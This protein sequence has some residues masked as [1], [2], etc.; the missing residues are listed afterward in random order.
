MKKKMTHTFVTSHNKGRRP[1]GGLNALCT[2]HTS[3]KRGFVE[4]LFQFSDGTKKS[5][6]WW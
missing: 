3:S 4:L 1:P 6:A 2:F 5:W